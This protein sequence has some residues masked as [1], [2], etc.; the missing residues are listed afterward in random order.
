M[1]G[2]SLYARAD[3][4]TSS[5]GK[6]YLTK[7]TGDAI[8]GDQVEVTMDAYFGYLP[9]DSASTYVAD[10]ECRDCGW[11]SQP[12]IRLLIDSDRRI[13]VNRDKLQ[14]SGELRS[15]DQVPLS[16]KFRLTLRVTLGEGSNG[17]TQVL[18]DDK[19]VIDEVGTT[20]P[21][22]Q[23]FKDAGITLTSEKFDYVQAG[24]TA[25]SHSTPVTGYFDNISI[26]VTR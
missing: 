12:G 25:N 14:V 15:T 2:Y 1:G 8:V 9:T 16:K 13:R 18:I 22:I 7:N 17:R 11:S 5:V 19:A 3:K 20:M 26:N 21:L 6:A 23:N 24:I 4:K 10:I